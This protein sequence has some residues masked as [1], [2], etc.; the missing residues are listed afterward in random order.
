MVVSFLGMIPAVSLV[1]GSL[2]AAPFLLSA[3]GFMGAMIIIGFFLGSM[4]SLVALGRYL[5][6]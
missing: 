3:G 1:L 6:F 5:K 4:G 2:T